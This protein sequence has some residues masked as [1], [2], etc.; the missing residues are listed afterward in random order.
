MW[1]QVNAQAMSNYI[2]I[3]QKDL[4]TPIFRFTPVDRILPLIV[5]GQN[6]LVSP[7]KWEDPFEN[8][9]NRMIFKDSGKPFKHPFRNRVY[10]QCWTLT[11]ETDATWRMYVPKGNGVRLK[12]TIKKLYQS[13]VQ[14]MH[15][16]YDPQWK[17]HGTINPYAGLACFIGRVDYKTEDELSS[18]FSDPKWVKNNLWGGHLNQAKSLLFKRE[19]FAPEQEIRLIFLEPHNNGADDFYHYALA[20]SDI[21]EQITFD[22]RMEDGLYKTY[23]SILRKHGYSGDIGKSTLYQVPNF[24]ITFSEKPKEENGGRYE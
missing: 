21:I 20:P 5:N 19:A 2:Y 14:S 7:R 23:S 12:T 18:L 8:I 16:S 9:L 17:E 11:E 24:E 22:P 3:D 13:L 1:K 10:G 4:K 15:H 6:T